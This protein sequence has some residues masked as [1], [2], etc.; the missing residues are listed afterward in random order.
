[1]DTSTLLAWADRADSSPMF[2]PSPITPHISILY[3]AYL[4]A[5]KWSNTCHSTSAFGSFVCYRIL[6]RTWVLFDPLYL[7]LLEFTMDPSSSSQYLG[8]SLGLYNQVT[9]HPALIR[10]RAGSGGF[11]KSNLSA[12]RRKSQAAAWANMHCIL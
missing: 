3:Y 9:T 2:R 12:S 4:A 11:T 5:G 1:M 8:P 10:F 6:Q 7:P